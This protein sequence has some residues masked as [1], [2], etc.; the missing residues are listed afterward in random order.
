MRGRSGPLLPAHVLLLDVLHVHSF[1]LLGLLC[2]LGCL[3]R[4]FLVLYGLDDTDGH[5]LP[6]VTDGETTWELKRSEP[7][8]NCMCALDHAII[9]KHF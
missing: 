5:R 6:H 3:S 7:L 9:T 2:S 4:D 1:L 8:E